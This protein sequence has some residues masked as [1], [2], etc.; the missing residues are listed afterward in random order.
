MA[1]ETTSSIEALVGHQNGELLE[2]GETVIYDF[3]ENNQFIGWHKE[4]GGK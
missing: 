4:V 3:D 2:S 1:E